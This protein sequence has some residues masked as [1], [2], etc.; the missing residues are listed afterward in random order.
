MNEFRYV[1]VRY[2]PDRERMEPVNVGLILQGL[3]RIDFRFSPHA[4]KRKDIDTEAFRRWKEFF[5]SEVQGAAAPLF[6]PERASPQF[7]RYLEELC[8]GPVLL[9]S[10]LCL[11]TEPSDSFDDVLDS[12]YQR[13]VA[14]P[15][16]VSPSAATRPTGRF[17]QIAEER[18]F[19]HRGMRRHAHV[20]VGAR[21]LWMAYRQV[22]NGEAIALD[23]VE[24][25]NQIG[26]TSYEIERL[27][28]IGEM[29]PQFIG[30]TVHGKP[31][32]YFLL[33]DE[34]TQPFTDQSQDEFQAMREDLENAVEL[35]AKKGGRIIRSVNEAEGI[36]DE[37]DD[38]LPPRPN[39]VEAV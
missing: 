34:L 25:A 19:L 3:G 27:P 9:S 2:V 22:D 13:L 11:G 29:L 37:L 26:P 38:K 7:L 6:Q 23:K 14:P 12:L 21:R 5:R 18:R 31:T 24:V 36:A 30:T 20:I 10:S 32:R 15:E 17:R 28:R 33:A 1:L 8:E 35:I 16:I 39:E 4:A